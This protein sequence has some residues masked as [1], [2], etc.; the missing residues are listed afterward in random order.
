MTQ[1]EEKELRTTVKATHDTVLKMDTFMRTEIRHV[2]EDVQG[3]RDT[4]YMP[5]TGLVYK[6]R[7]LGNLD[8]KVED[9]DKQVKG[10]VGTVIK[11]TCAMV[12]AI[13]GGVVALFQFKG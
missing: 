7:D 10:I 2:K 5:D 4:L 6:V 3:T 8:E 12:T 9:L 1:D 13:I 11:A